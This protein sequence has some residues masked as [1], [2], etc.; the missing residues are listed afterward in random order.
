L[1]NLLNTYYYINNHMNLIDKFIYYYHQLL[2][3]L[4]YSFSIYLFLPTL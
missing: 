1:N 3:N 2:L 4:L